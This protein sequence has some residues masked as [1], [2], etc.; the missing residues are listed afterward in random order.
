VIRGQCDGSKG[1]R[2]ICLR[3]SVAGRGLK[4]NTDVAAAIL[5]YRSSCAFCD[6]T[7]RSGHRDRVDIE[8]DQGCSISDAAADDH[9]GQ[10][11]FLSMVELKMSAVLERST[12]AWSLWLCDLDRMMRLHR[13]ARTQP[14]GRDLWLL[15]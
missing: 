5:F 11:D 15:G 9:D 2:G 14:S 13:L 6:G 12:M 8:V 1:D 7:R 3:S 4:V 10:N